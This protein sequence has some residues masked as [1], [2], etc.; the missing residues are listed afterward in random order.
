LAACNRGTRGPSPR[1][2][3]RTKCIVSLGSVPLPIPS[4]GNCQGRGGDGVRMMEDS[5]AAITHPTICHP[6][7]WTW[8]S[9]LHLPKSFSPSL[10][11]SPA[12][13]NFPP[14]RSILSTDSRLSRMTG[15]LRS[16]NG[17]SGFS[18]TS[19]GRS[20]RSMT[21]LFQLAAKQGSSSWHLL[22]AINLELFSKSAVDQNFSRPTNN[23]RFFW[24]VRPRSRHRAPLMIPLGWSY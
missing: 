6:S 13:S 11:L 18:R 21:C 7:C 9:T 17:Q 12:H 8:P 1:F 4:P 24:D 22:M 20:Q 3:A 2:R 16:R 5:L 15:R 23:L 14:R 19:V 10:K